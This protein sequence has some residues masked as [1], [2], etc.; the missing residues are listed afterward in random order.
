MS[1]IQQVADIVKERGRVSAKDIRI[2][3]K[4]ARQILRAMQN[5]AYDGLVELAEVQN[6]DEGAGRAPGMYVPGP[7]KRKQ[8]VRR[9]RRSIRQASNSVWEYAQRDSTV[10]APMTAGL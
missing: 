7:G 8:P 5:A 1:L 10:A 4:T 9:T 3:G 6:L 2:E